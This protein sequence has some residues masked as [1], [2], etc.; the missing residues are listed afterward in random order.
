MI[1]DCLT[2]W[3]ANLL[4]RGDGEAAVERLACEAATQAADRQ[5]PT[6]AVSNEVGMGVV[7]AS[8]EG[9]AYRDLLGR[10]NTIWAERAAEVQLVVAGRTLPLEA[11]DGA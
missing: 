1:V 2:F 5:A 6:L 8:A 4:G 7:P 10:T 9:R 3:V 11:D